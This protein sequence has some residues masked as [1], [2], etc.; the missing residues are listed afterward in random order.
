MTTFGKAKEVLCLLVSCKITSV[1]YGALRI[2]SF[3]TEGDAVFSDIIY[4]VETASLNA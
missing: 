1:T 2:S 4:F 3:I